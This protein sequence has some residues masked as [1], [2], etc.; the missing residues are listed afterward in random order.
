MLMGH[1][2]CRGTMMSTDSAAKEPNADQIA[3]W[4]GPGGRSWVNLQ[5]TWDVVLAPVLAAALARA[6]LRPGERVVDIGCG[7]GATT[8]EIGRLVGPDGRVLGLDISRPMLARAAERLPAG[9]SVE[10]VLADATTHSFARGE[11][12]LLFSRFGVMFFAEP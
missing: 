9:L 6:G 12:D 11:F 5:E 7:C 4:N 3:F 2:S 8:I 1:G 10:Y